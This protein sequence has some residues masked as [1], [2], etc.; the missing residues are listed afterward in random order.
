MWSRDFS[1]GDPNHQQNM[2][3][4]QTGR[5]LILTS[6]VLGIAASLSAQVTRVPVAAVTPLA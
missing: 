5:A 6:A 2:P 1:P 4:N 3:L